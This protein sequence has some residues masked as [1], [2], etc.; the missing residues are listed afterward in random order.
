MATSYHG[1][2]TLNSLFLSQFSLYFFP[3]RH[4]MY[5]ILI[6]VYEYGL[7]LM[8]KERDVE[9]LQ[10]QYGQFCVRNRRRVPLQYSNSK[11]K[12]SLFSKEREKMIYC[13]SAPSS[14]RWTS[15]IACDKIKSYCCCYVGYTSVWCVDD[16]MYWNSCSNQ[17]YCFT[18]CDWCVFYCCI[19]AVSGNIDIM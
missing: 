17:I 12:R 1:S 14:M 15:W 13:S 19:M 6:C 18:L 7:H 4:C 16:K 10:P 8:G 5:S 3:Q 9:E 2:R 11:L